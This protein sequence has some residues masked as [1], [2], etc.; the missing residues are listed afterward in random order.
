MLISQ[1]ESLDLVK[2]VTHLHC[3]LL[4]VYMIEGLILSHLIY[5]PLILLPP[6]E[7]DGVP[8]LLGCLKIYGCA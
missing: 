3:C 6:S 5:H 8:C 1:K 2:C 4:L 7:I